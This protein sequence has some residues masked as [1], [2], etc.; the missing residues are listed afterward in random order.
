MG[1]A[2]ILAHLSGEMSKNMNFCVLDVEA[3]SPRTHIF[4]NIS[5]SIHS[6]NQPWLAGKSPSSSMSIPIRPPTSGF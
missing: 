2:K 1:L 3:I 4:L 6:E 5:L